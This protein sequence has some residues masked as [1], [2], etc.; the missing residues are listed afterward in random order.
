MTESLF[1]V[2][3]GGRAPKGKTE[4]HDIAFA[5][6]ESIEDTYEQLM[7]QWFGT[8]EGLH[9]DSWIKLDHVDGYTITLSRHKT[10]SPVS[11]YFINL[12]AYGEGEFD[13]KHAR[14]F[15]VAS[16]I[17]EAKARGKRELFVGAPFRPHTDD[18]FEVDDCLELRQI[19]SFYVELRQTGGGEALK[20]VN[21][22]HLIPKDRV[23]AY[24]RRQATAISS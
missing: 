23:D 3:L 2:Y 7:D 8:P 20:P 4:L 15:L 12:G 13:E 19:G 14:T 11:L 21:G 17:A 24:L 9:L 10:P 1:A 18:L 22:Y 5:I 16:S 6:G